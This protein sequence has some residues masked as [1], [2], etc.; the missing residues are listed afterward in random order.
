MN[1]GWWVTNYDP[2][3]FVDSELDSDFS[4]SDSPLSVSVLPPVYP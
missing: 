4:R 3:R 2:L 1:L